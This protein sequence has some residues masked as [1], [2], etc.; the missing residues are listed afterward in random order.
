MFATPASGCELSVDADGPDSRPVPSALRPRG[1]A[2]GAWGG[3]GDTAPRA[4][5]ATRPDNAP[6]APTNVS[7]PISARDPGYVTRTTTSDARTSWSPCTLGAN[8]SHL[9]VYPRIAKRGIPLFVTCFCRFS[10]SLPVSF[11]ERWSKSR[12]SFGPSHLLGF[13]SRICVPAKQKLCD[14]LGLGAPKGHLCLIQGSLHLL[15]CIFGADLLKP[16]SCYHLTQRDAMRVM[17]KRDE[18]GQTAR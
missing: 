7:R 17:M 12:A 18:K 2:P 16:C 10:D 1:R 13:L 14:A 5:R 15:A 4:A 9:F 8:D 6:H 3:R 11:C